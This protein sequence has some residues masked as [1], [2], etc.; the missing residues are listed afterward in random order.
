[1][2]LIKVKIGQFPGT[3]KTVEI[4]RGS[5]IQC[6]LDKAE[7]SNEGYQIRLNNK[8]HKDT[9]AQVENGDTILLVKA[10]SGN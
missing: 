5:T 1:M 9:G 8:E 6:A 2:E 10:I 4:E 3:I 7:L